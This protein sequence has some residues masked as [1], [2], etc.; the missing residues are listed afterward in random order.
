MAVN[1]VGRPPAATIEDQVADIK[2]AVED[3]QSTSGQVERELNLEFVPGNLPTSVLTNDPTVFKTAALDAVTT[4]FEELYRFTVNT[5]ESGAK[6]VTSLDLNLFWQTLMTTGVSGS[7]KWQLGSGASPSTWVDITDVLTAIA[8][9][10]EHGRSGAFLRSEAAT[11]PFTL[12]L[13]GMV[14]IPGDVLRVDLLS[15][16]VVKVTYRVA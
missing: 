14:L 2:T 8:S 15:S 11:L 4:S 5:P 7:T 12:R 3:I 16:S 13:V 10:T 6:T 9:E 1:Y